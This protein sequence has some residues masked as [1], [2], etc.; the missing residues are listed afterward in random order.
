MEF[1]KLQKEELHE[2]YFGTHR[3]NG[4]TERHTEE[5]IDIV[6]LRTNCHKSEM[7]LGILLPIVK[8]HRQK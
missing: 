4:S 5:L 7:E 3:R 6:G 1:I 8:V 2:I